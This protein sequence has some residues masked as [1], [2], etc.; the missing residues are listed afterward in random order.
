MGCG[1]ST[2]G[3][4]VATSAGYSFLDLDQYI[5]AEHG[6]EVADL[7]REHGEAWF[8]EQEH[9]ALRYA[10]TLERHVIALGGGAFVP[11][12]NR[13]LI[14]GCGVSVYLDVPI[15]ILAARLAEARVRR[16]ILEDGQGNRLRGDELVTRISALIEARLPSYQQ[17]DFVFPIPTHETKARM[18]EALHAFLVE[19]GAL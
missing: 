8:R 12:R 3:P 4:R 19:Q 15:G 10:C 14:A 9:D 2:L 17:A 7:F 18:S 5:V 6:A 13:V 11:Q 16:P 1:K